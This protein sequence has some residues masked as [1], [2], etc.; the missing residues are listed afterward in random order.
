MPQLNCATTRCTI[1][2]VQQIVGLLPAGPRGGRSLPAVVPVTPRATTQRGERGPARRNP[3]PVQILQRTVGELVDGVVVHSRHGGRARLPPM[4]EA[5]PLCFAV[6]F[7]VGEYRPRQ[8]APPPCTGR[9]TLGGS[10]V[11]SA[12]VLDEDSG[13]EQVALAKARSD[14]AQ[15]VRQVVVSVGFALASQPVDPFRDA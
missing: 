11:R 12:V 5:H 10:G 15:P 6:E 3:S 9:G 13:V 2:I 7:S 8:K 14:S 1:A 4:L